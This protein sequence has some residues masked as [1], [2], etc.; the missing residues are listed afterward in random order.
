[1]SVQYGMSFFPK[2]VMSCAVLL[3]AVNAAA[4]PKFY[5]SAR[6][7]FSNQG[8]MVTFGCGGVKNDS[9]TG[10][11]GTIMV[12]LWALAAPYAS[13]TISGK[14]LGEYQLTALKPGSYYSPV[15]KTLKATL[16]SARKQYHLCLTVAE[17]RSNGYVITDHRNFSDRISLGPV[18]LFNLVGPWKW[19][20]SGETGNLDIHV[21][22]ITHTRSGSTGSLKLAVWATKSPYRGGGIEGFQLGAVTKAALKP[23][24]S[25]SA[26][27]NV[28]K[29]KM[30]PSGGYYISLVLSEFNGQEYRIVDH[31]SSSTTYTF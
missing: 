15:S 19:A 5:G 23:G 18:D 14:V 7:Q 3:M 16:P 12:R 25:Y 21:A 24:Y 11:T 1:M 6:Y 2:L 20:F 30:P 9:A 28:A 27:K 26:V 22:K 13:G 31:L 17:Y 4:A 10:S 29:F 8:T